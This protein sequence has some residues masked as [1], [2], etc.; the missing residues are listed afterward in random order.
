MKRNSLKTFKKYL[1]FIIIAIVLVWVSFAIFG[2]YKMRSAEKQY[3]KDYVKIINFEFNKYK[4]NAVLS[5]TI[6]NFG[7]RLLDS[8]VVKIDY[9]DK[10]E[11][12]LDSDATD[13]LKMAKDFLYPESGKVFRVD[14]TCPEETQDI[15]VSLK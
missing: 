10:N 6:Q 11:N 15:R 1:L 12:I 3:Y 7:M 5:I 13:V 14:V 8:I 2:Q 9:F 4:E